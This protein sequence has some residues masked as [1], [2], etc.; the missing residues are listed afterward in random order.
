MPPL[1][2]PRP[3]KMRAAAPLPDAARKVASTGGRPHSPPVDTLH[4]SDSAGPGSSQG[5]EAQ[6]VT[7]RTQAMAQ[8][9]KYGRELHTGGGSQCT[10]PPVLQRLE[11]Q[12]T[13]QGA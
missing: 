3:G 5:A 6:P 4:A 9:L 7:T 2:R 12:L 10:Q 1:M 11:R 13:L 8:A